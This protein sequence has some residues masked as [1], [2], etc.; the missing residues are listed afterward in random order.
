MKIGH[1]GRIILD[2]KMRNQNHKSVHSKVLKAALLTTV[3]TITL[4]P[5]FF[6]VAQPAAT[7]A[8]GTVNANDTTGVDVSAV[9]TNDIVLDV[10]LAPIV[11]NNHGIFTSTIDGDTEII[12]SAPNS[13]TATTGIDAKSTGVGNFTIDVNADITGTTGEGINVFANMGETIIYLGNDVNIRSGFAEGVRGEILANGADFTVQGAGS[14]SV[15]GGSHGIVVG[16]KGNI[17]IDGIGLVGSFGGDAVRAFSSGGD[18]VITN[19]NEAIGG[20]VGILANGDGGEIRISAED[21]AGNT[22]GIEVENSA[23]ST[24]ILIETTGNVQAGNTGIHTLHLG[25]GILSIKANNVIGYNENGISARTTGTGGPIEINTHGSI[26]GDENGISVLNF[27]LGNS[28]I[29]ILEGSVSG[30]AIANLSDGIDIESSVGLTNTVNLSQGTS[31]FSLLNTAIRAQNGDDVINNSGTVIGDVKLGSGANTFNNHS[32]GLFATGLVADLGMGNFLINSGTVS[33]GGEGTILTT[34]LTGDFIQTAAGTLISDLDGALATSDL[35]DITGS[36]D[37]AGILRPTLINPTDIQQDFTILT[38]AGGVTDSGLSVVDGPVT[39]FELLYPNANDVVV[40]TTVDFLID[41]LNPNQMNIAANLNNVLGLGGGELTQVQGGLTGLPDSE[42]IAKALDQ[43]GGESFFNLEQASLHSSLS[44]ANSLLSCKQSGRSFTVISEGQ[45]AWLQ[46]QGRVLNRSQSANNIG[47]DEQLTGLTSG[48]QFSLA[49]NW[50]LGFGMGYESGF[51]NTNAAAHADFRRFQ[52]GATLKYQHD[53]WLF[54]GSISGGVSQNDLAR[55][56]TFGGLNLTAN[57]APNVSFVSSQLRAAYLIE[58]NAWSFKP[59]LDFAVTHLNRSGVIEVG[60]G[61]A[62][63]DVS[64]SGNTYFS[65]SPSLEISREYALENETK[66]RAFADFG[67]TSISGDEASLT[68]SF[69]DAPAG[70][71]SFNAR[72]ELDRVFGDIELGATLFTEN[73]YNFSAKYQGRF[74]ENTSIHGAQLKA[75]FKF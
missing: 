23:S 43:L 38:A 62:N 64:G 68:A 37:I 40:S 67:I 66:I 6:A 4:V 71:G 27:G 53:S 2:V 41:G 69:L 70:A 5:A 42:S 7:V 39:S 61:A 16:S 24:S 11:A 73:G 46:P 33:P 28:T 14:G 58:R 36:A 22:N 21:V 12:V 13:I 18:I 15:I 32:G 51:L 17:F 30:G 57:S 52:A 50:H 35:V 1:I 56:I 44:F 72:G 19:I 59:T 74:S 60:G 26:I 49:P 63:L 34:S 54:A 9:G 75:S 8:E 48:A 25:S 20:Q 55:N 31:I 65:I 3:S 29:N 47:F 45:C 10:N